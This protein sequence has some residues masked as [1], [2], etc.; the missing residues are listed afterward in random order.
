MAFVLLSGKPAVRVDLKEA[1]P[2]EKTWAAWREAIVNNRPDRQAAADLAAL[3]WQPLRKHLPANTHTVW[4]VP[5]GQLSQVPWAAL[6]GTHPT[7]SCW[8]NSPSPW[9][10]TARSCSSACRTDLLPRTTRP[11]SWPSAA[12]PLKRPPPAPAALQDPALAPTDKLLAWKAL[13]G[14]ASEQ[15]QI[16]GLAR[17]ALNTEPLVLQGA[18]AS[19]GQVS[20]ALPKVR[21]ATWPR[22]AFSPIPSSVPP[23][24]SM[25]N[26][27]CTSAWNARRREHAARRCCR[28]WCWRGPTSRRRR[29][30]AS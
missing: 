18:A 28:G 4:L 10:R 19:I 20:A 25:R 9:C 26:N 27:S 1:A 8:R 2:I 5:D 13:P 16:A 29:R 21:F 23:S 11:P 3:V 12:W 17:K 7:P 24:R 6:P 14:T 15:T 22:T 30:A